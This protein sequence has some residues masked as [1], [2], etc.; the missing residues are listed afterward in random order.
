MLAVTAT[1]GGRVAEVL[2][3]SGCIIPDAAQVPLLDTHMRWDTSSVI[4]SC[5]EL[6]VEGNRLTIKGEQL[7]KIK[8][9]CQ[10]GKPVV[11]VADTD[12]LQITL[13]IDETDIPR[14][15]IGQR[16]AQSQE[17]KPIH[18]APPGSHRRQEK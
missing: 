9:Y 4:G 5:R 2:L 3:M 16:F 18:S 12:H 17:T 6:A 7:E 1:I 10:A 13:N 8:K 15:A 11:T 14:V